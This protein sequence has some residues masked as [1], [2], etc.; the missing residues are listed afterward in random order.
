[1][2]K[3]SIT[4]EIQL[5][6]QVKLARYEKSPEL[7][8][9]IL[10]FS[11]GTA[12]RQVSRNMI[13][14]THNSSHIITPF[15][16]GGSSAKLRDA[17]QMPAIGDVRNRLMALADQSLHGNTEIFTL[18]AHRLPMNGQHRILLR[19][20]V[21]MARGKHPLVAK[22]P[23]P[24]RKIIRN[25]LQ[26]FL[27]KMPPDFDLSGASIGNLVLAAGYLS[28]RRHL[29]P[30]IFLFSK[31][32]QV[33]GTVRPVVNKDL[34]LSAKLENGEF[35][36]GQHLLTGKEV[37]PLKSKVERLYLV[38]AGDSAEVEVSIRKKNWQLIGSAELICYPFGS[39]F[40]S[41]VANLLPKGV[42]SAISK[43]R[44]PKIYIPSTGSDP[45]TYG[46]RL[47]DQVEQLLAYLR[48]DDPQAITNKDVLNLVLIDKKKGKYRGKST[49]NRIKQWGVEVIHC[50][51]VSPKSSPHIDA[52]LL[53]PVL[54][55]LT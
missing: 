55:S 42:G 29:D 12:L 50:P 26:T 19:E 54:L 21:R 7:G 47:F 8:P 53:V 36:I 11:G 3:L 39:F 10:F 28:N 31:L 38:S 32:V 30:V 18:F 25:H 44:C 13:R 52:D 5:P 2:V 35:I 16:S 6:S 33:R 1:M 48:K 45:E 51:L 17:F 9:E 24:M 22:I 40:S 43:N 46:M 49:I 14:Y 20:L 15:D 37:P 41:L 27:E 34:C 23:D 4:R